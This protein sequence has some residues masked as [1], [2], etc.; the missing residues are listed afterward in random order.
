MP[1]SSF[2][3]IQF[4]W[5]L[6]PPK[7]FL[8]NSFALIPFH[9]S[10]SHKIS[11]AASTTILILRLH[12]FH[13]H[14]VFH[15]YKCQKSSTIHIYNFPCH[16]HLAV[17]PLFLL[18]PVTPPNSLLSSY[19]LCCFCIGFFVLCSPSSFSRSILHRLHDFTTVHISPTHSLIF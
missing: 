16:I 19:S 10:F 8:Q 3:I 13:L 11:L 4:R 14:N 6:T 1:R 9:I 18:C 7:P 12:L 15:C 5:C 17:F 2:S